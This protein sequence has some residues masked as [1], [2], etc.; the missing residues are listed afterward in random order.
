MAVAVAATQ[1]G[2]L[3]PRVVV[4][5]T[6]L[7][8]SDVVTLLRYVAGVPTTVRGLDEVTVDDVA[9]SVT[10]AEFPFGVEITYTARVND[11]EVASSTPASYALPGGGVILSDAVTGLYAQVTLVDWEEKEVP[12]KTSI[13]RVGARTVVVSGDRGTPS[14]QLTVYTPTEEA[15]LSFAELLTGATAGVV[16]IRQEGGY[17]DIDAYLAVTGEVQR[18]L[19]HRDGKRLWILDVVETE[20][21]A[22]ELPSLGFTFADVDAAYAGLTFGDLDTDFAGATFLDFDLTDW[23]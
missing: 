1:L 19:N 4:A 9:V 22:P 20:S 23:T 2:S 17:D 15:R 5:V 18:R 13:F 8:V 10:D 3:P 6:G 12:R 11:V 7:T 21:W 16:Q 14:S